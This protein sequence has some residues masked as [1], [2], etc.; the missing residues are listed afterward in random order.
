MKAKRNTVIFFDDLKETAQMRLI[1]QEMWHILDT[2][3]EPAV[4]S[5]K[6]DE[7]LY[8]YDPDPAKQTVEQNIYANVVINR[9]SVPYLLVWNC[10]DA[11]FTTVM[12]AT[13]E[14]DDDLTDEEREEKNR[15]V[16]EIMECDGDK[17]RAARL[18]GY[19]INEFLSK[20]VRYHIQ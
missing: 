18:L 20:L 15:I 13:I 8:G 6:I 4:R 7:E 10:E 1:S 12:K 9:V 11:E 5:L 14:S 19:D 3:D 17:K 2:E 16:T